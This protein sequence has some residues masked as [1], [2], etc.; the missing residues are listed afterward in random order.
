MEPRIHTQNRLFATPSD[1]PPKQE[2][3]GRT[4]PFLKSLKRTGM[5][6][7]T[8]MQQILERI[9]LWLPINDPL[10]MELESD[11][12]V[13]LNKE[14]EQIKEAYYRGDYDNTVAGYVVGEEECEE[15]YNETYGGTQ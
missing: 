4:K 9:M 15:Y 1:L 13:W 14:K 5:C 10:R 2:P 11:M 7:Q 8:A 6:N 12:S 3:N